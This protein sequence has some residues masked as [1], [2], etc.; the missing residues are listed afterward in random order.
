MWLWHTKMS[1][2]IVFAAPEFTFGETK[3]YSGIGVKL[4]P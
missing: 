4:E 2:F 1:V 3:A